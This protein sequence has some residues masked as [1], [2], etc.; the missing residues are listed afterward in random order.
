[1]LGAEWLWLE[2]CHGRSAH[3]ST[4]LAQVRD[5]R[6]MAEQWREVT[7]GQHAFL[8]DLDDEALAVPLSYVNLAGE[9]RVYSLGDVLRHVVNHATYHRGQVAAALRQLGVAP[10]STDFTAF[11]DE[12]ARSLAPDVDASPV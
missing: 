12:A 3:P 11:L 5:V 4:L 9:P 6:D 7:R 1:M 10:P 8:D 2:R